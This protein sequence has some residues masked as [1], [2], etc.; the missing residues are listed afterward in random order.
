[1]KNKK[2]IYFLILL[3]ISLVYFLLKDKNI[4]SKK[5]RYSKISF[6][7]I[8]KSNLIQVEDILN[9]FENKNSKINCKIESKIKISRL[10]NEVKENLDSILY[11]KCYE[12]TD[13]YTYQS[14]FDFGI[15]NDEVENDISFAKGTLNKLQIQIEKNDT[16]D[17]L[18]YSDFKKLMLLKFSIEPFKSVWYLE[19]PYLYLSSDFFDLITENKKINFILSDFNQFEVSGLMGFE[20]DYCSYFDIPISTSKIILKELERLTFD[21]KY[22]NEYDYL[23]ELNKLNLS[24]KYFLILCLE[25]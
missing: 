14:K 2:I 3:M 1:M 24:D 16:L 5:L 11:T 21:D 13:F 18:L 9:C 10:L 7:L 15:N 8:K 19:K 17:S 6:L 4:E 12:K 22:K 20:N 25:N 23:V